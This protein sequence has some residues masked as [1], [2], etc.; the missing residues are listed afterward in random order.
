MGTR[1]NGRATY[2]TKNASGRCALAPASELSR[3]VGLA[4]HFGSYARR[5]QRRPVAGAARYPWLVSGQGSTDRAIPGGSSPALRPRGVVSRQEI[6]YKGRRRIRTNETWLWRYR[7]TLVA[8]DATGLLPSQ[9]FRVLERLPEF[10]LVMLEVAFDFAGQ[11]TRREVRQRVLF[12]KTR[13]SPSRGYADYWGRR[14][15]EDSENLS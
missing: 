14:S 15:N 1:V 3:W 5:L 2:N 13:P 8:D 6:G 4:R 10:H 12:G 9:V 7:V 11:L